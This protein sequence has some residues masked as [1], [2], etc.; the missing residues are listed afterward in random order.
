MTE[1]RIKLLHFMAQDFDR[2]YRVSEI[3]QEFSCHPLTAYFSLQVL[4]SYGFV[5]KYSDNR[6]K[7]TGI[8]KGLAFVRENGQLN[9]GFIEVY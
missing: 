6:Y 1:T 5:R 2:R 9:L 7:L 3:A 8:A 4:I